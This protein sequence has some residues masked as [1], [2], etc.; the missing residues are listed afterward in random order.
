ME[1]I[2]KPLAR[3]NGYQVSNCGKFKHLNGNISNRKPDNAGYIRALLRDGTHIALHLLIAETFL[4]KPDPT[5]TIVNHIDG[6]RSNN[7]VLNLEWVTIV[8]NNTRKVNPAKNLAK[9]SQE[10]LPGEYWK[11]VVFEGFSMKASNLGRVQFPNGYKTSGSVSAHNYRSFCLPNKKLR[12]IHRVVCTAFYGSPP[13]ELHVVNHIDENKQ[14][15]KPENLE[16]VT[17]QQNVRHSAK[18]KKYTPA[19]NRRSVAQYSKDKKTLLN[20]FSCVSE[21]STRTGINRSG[22]QQYL[23]GAKNLRHFGN[24]HWAYL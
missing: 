14:N 21:A 4:P 6:N 3:D 16:W 7:N 23:S 8:E 17:Q 10:D 24:F 15:N 20:T 11:D 19:H 13:T 2:W 18:S 9:H 1:E 12:L 5:K 22:I